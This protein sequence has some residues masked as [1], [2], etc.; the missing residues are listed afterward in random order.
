VTVPQPIRV[1]II[2]DHA[3]FHAGVVS[4]LAASADDVEVGYAGVDLAQAVEV[5]SP[6][7]V[8]LLD[9]DLGPGTPSVPELVGR[10]VDRGAG[11]LIVSALGGARVVRQGLAAGALG[12]VNK[13]CEPQ[14][15]IAG[16]RCVAAGRLFLTVDMAAVLGED[17]D[18]VPT[19][20]AQ[21]IRALRLYTSGLT[22]EAVA[23]RMGV[24]ATTAKEYL[25]RVRTKYEMAS[26]PARTRAE[27]AAVAAEDGLLGA[28]RIPARRAE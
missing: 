16:I 4:W 20:S 8:V 23:R 14:D 7:D 25:D 13:S 2:D 6:G 27:L 18:D 15:V 3:L 17:P 26:R 21:E 22:L 9:L 28:D 10:F 19:L 11:V 12:Y 24:R 5:T 1:V